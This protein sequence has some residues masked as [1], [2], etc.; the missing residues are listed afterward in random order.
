M[1]DPTSI[2]MQ[3]MPAL[4]AGRD[5]IGIAPTGAGKTLAFLLPLVRHVYTRTKARAS[6]PCPPQVC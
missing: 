5:V 1:E 3:G 2:Q 6:G 4:M